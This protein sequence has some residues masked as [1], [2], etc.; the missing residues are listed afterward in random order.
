MEIHPQMANQLINMLQKKG[1][2]Y[3]V[4]PSKADAQMVYLVRNGLAHYAISQDAH[5]VAA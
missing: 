4:A 5:M 2:D 1:V 3:I